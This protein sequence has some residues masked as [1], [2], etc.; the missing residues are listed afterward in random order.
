MEDEGKL[1]YR[2]FINEFTYVHSYNKWEIHYKMVSTVST[3]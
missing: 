1:H 2:C 3:I